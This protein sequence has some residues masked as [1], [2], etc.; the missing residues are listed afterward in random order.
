MKEGEIISQKKI[1]LVTGGTKGIGLQIVKRLSEDGYI[2]LSNSQTK[3]SFEETLEDLGEMKKYVIMQCADI[4]IPSQVRDMMRR[5]ENRY[6]GLDLL[7]N[8][9]GIDEP[10]LLLEY[11]DEVFRK[12]LNINLFGK[13]LC[14]KYAA[15]LLQG[16]KNSS[17]IL[18][19]SRLS[20][21]PI[22]EASAYCCSQAGVRMLT[23]VAALE[24]API[25]VNC[26]IPGFTDT[27]MNRTIFPDE[28]YWDEIKQEIPLQIIKNG[29]DIAEMISFL[30]SERG[31]Y[32][33]GGTFWVDGGL[34]LL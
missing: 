17:I 1:A 31:S 2:V 27:G 30:S 23:K 26:I 24:L 20:E 33:T 19:S 5:I 22:R 21:K 10:H 12:I 14:I 11:E 9:A 13:F 34:S 32:I 8:N 29:E 6:G 18:I 28:E 25:R 3:K 4:A 7:V 16:R 15:K